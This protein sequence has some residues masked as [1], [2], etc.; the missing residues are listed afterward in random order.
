MENKNKNVE[1]KFIEIQF[2]FLLPIVLWWLISKGEKVLW[3]DK[4]INPL[5][6]YLAIVFK[7][8][9]YAWLFISF[10]RFINYIFKKLRNA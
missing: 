7:F 10:I 5:F 3:R 2:H 1:Q 4:T 9:I 6:N 8:A